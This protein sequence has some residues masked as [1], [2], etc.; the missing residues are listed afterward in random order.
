MTSIQEIFQT[1][2][3]EGKIDYKSLNPKQKKVV[4]DIKECKTGIL[5]MNKDVC[6]CCGHT[7]IHYNSCKNVN[8]PN[9]QAYDRE[10]WIHKESRFTLNVNYF[11][12]VFTIPS[13]LNTLVLIDPKLLYNIL[14]ETSSKTLKELSADKK[15]LGA[16]I[17]FTSVLHT[18]G[19]N[20][21][22][23]P[24][25]HC[26]IPGGGMDSLGRWKPSKKKF[27][28]PVKVL[29]EVFR[30]KF[31]EQLKKSFDTSKLD[32]KNQLQEIID[33]CY[34]KQWVVYTKKPMKSAKHVIRYLGRYTHRIAISN[35]RIIKYED[36]KV[37]FKFKDYKDN[38]KLKDMTLDDT[39]FF[40]RFML[41]ILPKGF[42]KIRHY[43]FLGN[44]NKEERMAA[45]RTATDTPDPGPLIIVPE[46]IISGIIKRD[47]TICMICGQ[48]R[49]PQLE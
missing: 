48:K 42:M 1:L 19:Q 45:I 30:G 16:K 17:G 4:K 32:N 26:I 6:E 46:E 5:G 44:K 28:L 22:L 18:W 49:H 3:I 9:C 27:F 31:L 38:N 29:S 13:E 23:H 8:C 34:E 36:N 47:V 10:V 40:R 14:F 7:E 2:D 39:E 33:V 24:H 43:G 35:A 25:I 15:Y 12:V 11:H 37:T 20:V 41:H 21:S